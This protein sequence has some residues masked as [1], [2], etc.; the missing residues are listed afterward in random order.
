[1]IDGFEIVTLGPKQHYFYK[2]EILTDIQMSNY[3]G[4]SIKDYY[5]HM[6]Q[7]FNGYVITPPPGLMSR[8]RVVS[9]LYLRSKEDCEK[10]IEWLEAYKVMKELTRQPAVIGVDVGY[11]QSKSSIR[12]V[13]W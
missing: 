11:G 13:N 4:I 1:M 7:N 5:N 2:G 3:V 6:C 12:Q 9:T 10:A 8:D